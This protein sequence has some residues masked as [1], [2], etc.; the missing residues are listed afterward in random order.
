MINK[1]PNLQQ[2]L[3]EQVVQDA[4]RDRIFDNLHNR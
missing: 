1:E 3:T 4:W 2:L